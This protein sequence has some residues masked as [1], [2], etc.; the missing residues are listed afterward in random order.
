MTEQKVLLERAKTPESMG[1]SSKA[2]MD[3]VEDAKNNNLE[4]HS[5]MVI[6]HGKVAA[7]WYNKPFTPDFKHMM[8]SVSKSFTA[9][10][11]GFAISEGLLTLD[12]KLIDLFPDYA[13]KKKDKRFDDLKIFNLLTMT[14]GK[15][16]NLLADKSKIDWIDDFFTSP[17]I[18]AP[19]EEYLYVNENIYMLAATIK[20]LTGM[21][22]VEYLTPRLFEPLGIEAPFW[23]TDPKM[24][25][26]AGGWGLYIST[27]DFAK[28]MLC[29]HQ[30]GIFDG[31]QV[32]PAEWVREAKKPQVSNA[33]SNALRDCVAGY[34][35]CFWM[36]DGIKDSYR[37]D[38][39]FSQFGIDCPNEDA[40]IIAT[41]GISDEGAARECIWRHFP[42]G[43][44][45]EDKKASGVKIVNSEMDT[46]ALSYRSMLEKTI[47]GRTIKLHHSVIL[48]LIG[49]PVSVIPLT[50]TF[51]MT[52]RAGNINNVKFDF[53]ENECN[54]IWDEGDEFNTVICGMDGHYRYGTIR[55]G[56]VDFKVCCYAHWL[57]DENLNINI[58]PIETV[59]KRRLNFTFKGNN[60]VVMKPSSMPD[61]KNFSKYIQSCAGDLIKNPFVLAIA[62]KA[63]MLVPY[64]VEPKQRGKFID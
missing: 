54:M 49:F 9:T 46:P 48:S 3:F 8:F 11:I 41:S 10:A 31:K 39:M 5:F 32:I 1:V 13:P 52:D 27:E 7:E 16:P 14:A 53:S 55:L 35:F 23:E 59:A 37:A 28:F 47:S 19:G 18:F 63:I 4:F 56:Q 24:H 40:V 17:W 38:G 12:T 64:I 26:E 6:R 22:V 45:K 57:D 15:Q 2:V 43:F 58:R 25:I 62:K 29:Y 61:T 30:G 51:M 36:N 20:K 33:G 44:I 21:G 50:V 60:R 34:G 42:D